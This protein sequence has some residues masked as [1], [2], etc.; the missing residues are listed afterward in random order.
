MAWKYD[1]ECQKEILTRKEIE[2]DLAHEN[3][4]KILL[5]IV[6]ILLII[7]GEL[8]FC[9]VIDDYVNTIMS[10]II[11]VFMTA[12]FVGVL[13]HA[14]YFNHKRSEELQYEI[15]EDCVEDVWENTFTSATSGER[16]R[17]I[18]KFK[19]F[20]TFET[21][22][23]LWDYPHTKKTS[24]L[25]VHIKNAFFVNEEYYL[26]IVNNKIKNFYS[27]RTFEYKAT[28]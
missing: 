19:K 2:Y 6:G 28:D 24:K 23:Y 3:K 8:F 4:T 21:F 7:F 5:D 11:H 20:G 1:E 15:V 10:I 26:I 12:V 25:T 17:T 22:A 13:F 16:K 18:V 14:C 27:K 9:F